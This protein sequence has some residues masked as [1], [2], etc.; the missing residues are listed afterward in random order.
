SNDRSRRR[1][2]AFI[3]E[4]L[5]HEIS[6]D[7]LVIT[8]REGN[9]QNSDYERPVDQEIAMRRLFSASKINGFTVEFDLQPYRNRTHFHDRQVRGRLV[10][11]DASVRT[12][13]WDISSGLDNLMDQSKE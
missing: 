1:L 9:P 5:H 12:L 7:H 10:S 8:W 2:I 6:I 13:L 4:M 11:P 3:E